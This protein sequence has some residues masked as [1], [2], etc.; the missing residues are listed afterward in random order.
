MEEDVIDWRRIS[1]VL[2]DLDGV[3]YRSGE[4]L[5]GAQA[6][7][8]ALEQRG[9]PCCALTNNARATP[10]AYEHKLAGMG[11]NLPAERIVTA[12]SATAEWLA[13]HGH[14]QF[15][16]LGSD[17]LRECLLARGLEE[18]AAA[19]MLVIGIDAGLNYRD[20]AGAVNHLLQ[21]ENRAVATNADRL[22]PVA[23]GYE[24]ECG[25]II[26]FLEY[27]TGRLIPT[28]GKPNPWIFR[29]ALE[30][31]GVTPA[32]AVMIGD[33]LDTDIMGARAAGVPSVLVETGSPIPHVTPVAPALRLPDIR[34]VTERL[35]AAL[36]GAGMRTQ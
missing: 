7:F 5:A 3:I 25:A 10:E 23:G 27:A 35:T 16:M 36:G 11:V 2:L 6:F 19:Q 30:R 12:G 34:A 29:Y 4:P 20:L 22:I 33:T 8:A 15:A 14:R 24:P 31:L 26:A 1:G 9:L 28:I 18:S 21:A 32:Q 17:P 13:R